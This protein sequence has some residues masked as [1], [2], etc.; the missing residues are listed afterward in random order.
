MTKDPVCGETIDPGRALAR[1][2]HAARLYYFC[3]EACKE[4][5]SR[6]PQRYAERNQHGLDTKNKASSADG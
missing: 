1:T 4:A 2:E 3:S 6:D 5:F